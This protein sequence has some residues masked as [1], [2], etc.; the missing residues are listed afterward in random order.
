MKDRNETYRHFIP[1]IGL[2]IERNTGNVPNDGRFHVIK[3]GRVVQSF[4]SRRLA[5]ERFRQL[6]AESGFKSE[7]PPHVERV[8]PLDESAERYAMAKD[9]FWAEGPKYRTKGGRGGRGGI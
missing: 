1:K 6:L 4:R 2:S 5:E 7:L 8:N 3:A 9:I